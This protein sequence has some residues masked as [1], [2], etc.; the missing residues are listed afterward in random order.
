MSHTQTL[1]VL[2]YS[3][4]KILYSCSKGI[5]LLSYAESPEQGCCAISFSQGMHDTD[6]SGS[7]CTSPKTTN[8]FYIGPQHWVW[9]IIAQVFFPQVELASA[10]LLLPPLSWLLLVSLLLTKWQ[11]SGR[12]KGRPVCPGTNPCGHQKLTNYK[13][14][15]GRRVQ[16]R[17]PQTHYSVPGHLCLSFCN[18]QKRLYLCIYLNKFDT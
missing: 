4:P 9:L 18:R 8:L 10:P 1:T 2:Q 14:E 11:R 16:G 17:R 13:P 12:G 6:S 7:C 5:F 15:L 3:R